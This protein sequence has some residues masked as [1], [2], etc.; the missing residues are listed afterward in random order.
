MRHAGDIYAWCE[1]GLHLMKN[2]DFSVKVH[3]LLLRTFIVLKDAAV[4]EFSCEGA[5]ALTKVALAL[6]AP[7]CHC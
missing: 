2:G 1:P 6:P 3:V 5:K 4:Q 7:P